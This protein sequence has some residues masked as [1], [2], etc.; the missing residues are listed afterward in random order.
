MAGIPRSGTTWVGQALAAHP[1]VTYVHEPDNCELDC[2]APV[3]TAG[4]EVLP[5]P[6]PGARHLRYRLTWELAFRGGFPRTGILG[7][8]GYL[9]PR[10]PRR[11][12][13]PLLL[14]TAALAARRRP[15]EGWCMV[16]T[17]RVPFSLAWVA[18][19]SGAQ[20][21]LVVRHPLNML[22]GWR[23][24]GWGA[25]GLVAYPPV[26]TRL[27]PLGLWPPPAA[28]TV[29]DTTWTLCTLLLF[30]EE[31]AA[32]HPGWWRVRHEHL[33]NDP[34]QGFRRL[35]AAMGL[36]WSATVADVLIAA[37]V[38]GEGWEVRRRAQHQLA[39]WR[40][41]PAADLEAAVRV[42]ARFADAVPPIFRPYLAE[43]DGSP[44]PGRQSPG[45]AADILCP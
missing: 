34:V 2:F 21:L 41:L 5:R 15:P 45:G 14:G 44:A 13:G 9:A 32:A 10:L 18:E 16:K 38:E 43:I 39:V 19:V 36:E 35:V 31:A 28:G 29:A 25:Y 3:G 33:C 40:R 12:R 24:L 8:V 6:R 23:R 37:D 17:V 26:R 4:M 27:E 11:I 20:V 1:A 22:A 42:L 30:H 7:W